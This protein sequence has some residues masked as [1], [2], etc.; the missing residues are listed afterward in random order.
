MKT[1]KMDVPIEFAKRMLADV[2]RQ[3]S[4]K[5]RARDA[6]TA[7]ISE[8]DASAKNV[9]SQ[10]QGANGESARQ[11]KGENLTRIKNYLSKIPENKGA[12]ASEISRATGIGTSSTAFTLAY[13]TKDF[14]RDDE[15]KLWKLKP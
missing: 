11:P 3:I 15:T 2:E 5:I 13:Y 10:L 12:R 6:L 4:E 7:E 1:V 8:L 9:R 14:V